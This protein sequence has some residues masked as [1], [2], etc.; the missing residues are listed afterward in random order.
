MLH[1]VLSGPATWGALRRALDS[2]VVALAPDLLGNGR[3]A[4]PVST[5]T[6]DAVVEHLEPL[7]ERFQPTHILGHSM[8]AIVA[9]ALR[10]RMP[11]AFRGIGV[12]GL[13]VYEDRRA[14]AAFLAARGRFVRGILAD[15]RRAHLLC[16]AAHRLGPI[17][18]AILCRLYP[19]LPR[20]VVA[21]TFDHRS[22]AHGQ[23]LEDI[24]FAG[25]VPG[26]AREGSGPVAV[27]HGSLDRAAPLDA[28]RTL[29]E[30]CGFRFTE[31]AGANHQVVIGQAEAVAAWTRR[32]LLFPEFATAES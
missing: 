22:C 27:L 29:A 23:A 20:D 16:F 24:V 31:L 14:A 6:L 7:V 21:A 19:S 18:P 13:P 8:G 15:H 17:P 1:G 10:A 12:I 32:E 30:A 28:A 25:S 5:Y 4:A 9:L 3:A 2:D 26:I 11:G